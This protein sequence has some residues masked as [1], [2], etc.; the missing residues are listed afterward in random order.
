MPSTPHDGLF[1]ATFEQ[2][3]LARSELEFV[4]PAD[5]CALLDL[6]TLEVVPGSFRDEELA[7]THSDLLYAVRT[8][9]GGQALVYILFEHQST[10]DSAMAFR[11]LRYIVRIWERWMRDHATLPIVLPIVMHHG[12]SGWRAAPELATMLDAS[13]ELLA[14]TRRFVPHFEFLLDDLSGLSLDALATRTLHAFARLVQIA[15]W[16][17][18]SR[19][20]L[21]RA[22]PVMAALATTLVRDE[23][24]RQL[25]LQLYAYLWRAA[26]Q[27]VAVAEMRSILLQVAGPEGAEDAVNAVEQLIA[28][29]EASGRA[30]GLRDAV[31]HVL[32]ARGLALSDVGRA[33][34]A[35]CADVDALTAWLER[36]ATSASEAE[37]FAGSE[38]T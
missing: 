34:V 10:F 30:R 37:V 16:S 5:V 9:G 2:P 29:G 13:P 25:L 28:Q 26:P 6:G 17:W 12:E 11:L 23:R 33:R 32:A 19:E 35:S 14:A 7:Q 3:D 8:R 31:L 27:D 1:K 22:A 18:R 15:M 36:A 20:R 24:T 21:E 4:L 38:V